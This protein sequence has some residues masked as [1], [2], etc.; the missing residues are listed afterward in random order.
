MLKQTWRKVQ[1]KTD[2]I[3]FST[4]LRSHSFVIFNGVVEVGEKDIYFCQTF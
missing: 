4:F 3:T 2:I 1:N